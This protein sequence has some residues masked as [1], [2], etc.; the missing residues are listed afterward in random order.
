MEPQTQQE[1]KSSSEN[2]QRA[3]P[4]RKR[5]RHA[6]SVA[7]DG[8]GVEGKSSSQHEM[9]A[10]PVTKK[11][12]TTTPDNTADPCDFSDAVFSAAMG[13]TRN[14]VLN[15]DHENHSRPAAT[16]ASLPQFSSSSYLNNVDI[17]TSIDTDRIIETV[18]VAIRAPILHLITP[19]PSVVDFNVSA[20][21]ELVDTSSDEDETVTAP[22][23]STSLVAA[24]AVVESPTDINDIKVKAQ[25]K[26]GT[27]RLLLLQALLALVAF[28]GCL[29]GGSI[30]SLPLLPIDEHS[31]CVPGGGFSGFW[32]TLGRLRSIPDP[33]SKNYYCYS[34]GCLGVVATMLNH[35]MEDM[36]DIAHNV[37]KRWRTGDL[38]HYQVVEAFLD[39]VLFGL[40][41]PVENVHNASLLVTKNG[42]FLDDA[43]LL[44]RLNI[45]T[46][47]RGEWGGLKATVRTPNSIDS[48]HEMLLQT[49]WIPYAV[50]N[51]LWL[52]DHMDGAFSTA[53]HPI[54]AHTLGLTL[55]PELVANVLNVNLG[56]DKVVKFWNEGLAKGL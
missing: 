6:S 29:R 21:A 50:G 52:K 16:D 36:Y 12:K 9:D 19:R 41:S 1:L 51:D 33:A 26:I 23:A 40:A 8:D 30:A 25:P 11:S 13:E 49:T 28:V 39:K 18:K 48:L 5:S 38:D 42:Q 2:G 7:G 35:S 34:A 3:L 37:Q 44:S 46:T 53:Q 54:C 15:S 24:M 43:D 14:S 20:L 47:V 4:S 17:E 55:Y 31:I 32:F 10:A 56:R 27:I 45:I 22:A